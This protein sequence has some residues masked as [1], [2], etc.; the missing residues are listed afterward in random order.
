[1][2]SGVPYMLD[3]IEYKISFTSED[4]NGMMQVR[5][6][7]DLG[8]EATTIH[9]ENGTKMP[10]T[11]AEFGA[12]AAWFVK[13]AVSFLYENT[14]TAHRTFCLIRRGYGKE[15]RNVSFLACRRPT[16][17]CHFYERVT[18]EALESV[19]PA[20]KVYMPS[21]TDDPS[22]DSSTV[23]GSNEIGETNA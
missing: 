8:V 22:V 5:T 18:Y 4:G 23:I 21:V 17:K 13:N 14:R 7:F 11:P 19:E 20:V 3:G 16:R 10:I 12:F 1:M 15:I 2:L 6:A 9:F